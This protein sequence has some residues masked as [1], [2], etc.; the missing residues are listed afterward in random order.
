MLA[1]QARWSQGHAKTPVPSRWQATS[2]V[3]CFCSVR[4]I[5]RWP[6]HVTSKPAIQPHGRHQA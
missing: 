3:T 5:T 2:F 4:R 6:H 1:D